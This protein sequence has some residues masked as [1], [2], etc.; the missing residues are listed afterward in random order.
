M[1]STISGAVTLVIQGNK[2]IYCL[3]SL[4]CESP[5]NEKEREGKQL[6]DTEELV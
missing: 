1:P 5:E 4:T 6:G 3:S 2:E